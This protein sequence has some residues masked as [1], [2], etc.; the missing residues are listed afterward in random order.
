MSKDLKPIYQGAL[1][2]LEDPS[3][4]TEEEWCPSGFGS[5]L[6]DCAVCLGGA[7]ARACGYN[8]VGKDRQDY[9]PALR[10]AFH[11]LADIIR[12]DHVAAASGESSAIVTD[13]NDW[14][15]HREVLALLRKALA[16]KESRQ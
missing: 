6:D 14:A 11:E 2:Y 13:F 15:S 4:W 10:A 5:V 7:L 12:A 9:P 16:A 3:H 8:I 1:D